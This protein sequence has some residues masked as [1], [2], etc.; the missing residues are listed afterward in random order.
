MLRR[1]VSDS[2]PLQRTYLTTDLIKILLHKDSFIFL[3]NI[4]ILHKRLLNRLRKE[5]R[6]R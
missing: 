3:Q 2:G 6:D 4:G 5:W 1:Y